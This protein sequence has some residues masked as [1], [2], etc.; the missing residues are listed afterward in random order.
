[1][2]APFWETKSLGQ[3]DREEWES[4]C[5]GCALCCLHKLEDEDSGDVFFS[6]V[7]CRLLDLTTCRCVDYDNRA[8]RVPDCIVLDAKRS[9]AFAWLPA[10]CA[11]R[12]LHEGKPLPDWHPLLTGDPESVHDAGISVRGRAVSEDEGSSYTVLSDL[13]GSDPEA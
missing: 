6:D 10:S 9:A 7:A 12:R 5:D 4:L 13:A 11:Y 2:K 8:R 3:M 1:M